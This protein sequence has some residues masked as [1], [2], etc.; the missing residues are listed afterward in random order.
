MS[1]LQF[2]GFSKPQIQGLVASGAA[3][4]GEGAAP[5]VGLYFHTTTGVVDGVWLNGV[6]KLDASGTPA[7]GSIT[8]AKFVS[9]LIDGAAGVA[10]LRSLTAI[11]LRIGV[12]PL[13]PASGSF[14]TCIHATRAETQESTGNKN[15]M[16]LMPAD[17]AEEHEFDRIA[18][19]VGTKGEGAGLALRLGVYADDG[20]GAKPTGSPL[21]ESGEIAATEAGER[22]AAIT[23]KLVPTRYWLAWVM[24]GTVTVGPK[25]TTCSPVGAVAAATLEPSNFGSWKQTGVTGALPAIGTLEAAATCPLVGLRVK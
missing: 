22:F 20:T 25:V 7:D 19:Y 3:T 6:K 23:Q 15:I 8:Q 21:F 13:K 18:A 9:S 1:G 11:G 12:K 4:E 16:F 17:L 5:S 2:L 10:T 14:L 24:Q